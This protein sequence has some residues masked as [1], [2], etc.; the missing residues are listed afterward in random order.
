MPTRRKPL[1]IIDHL[2]A[3]PVFHDE[4]A[5]VAYWGTHRL[6]DTLL[7]QM[8]PLGDDAAPPARATSSITLRMDPTP[9]WHGSK[10]SLSSARFPISDC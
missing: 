1:Q 4:A 9:S 6:S 7:S 8:Q 10:R 3:I 2:A 5:E